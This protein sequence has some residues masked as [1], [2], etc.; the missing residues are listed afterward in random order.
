MVTST[1]AGGMSQ[2][3][4]AV[5]TVLGETKLLNPGVK[6][7]IVFVAAGPTVVANRNAYS[8][9]LRK[10]GTTQLR[11]ELLGAEHQVPPV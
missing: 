8:T 1:G 5:E 11:S 3:G 4:I 7:S 6:T 9:P 2:H 10:P